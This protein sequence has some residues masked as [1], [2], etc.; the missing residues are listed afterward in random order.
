M[1]N[2]EEIEK[3]KDFMMREH[4]TLAISESVTSGHLQAALSLADGATNFFQ[5]GLT[6]YNLGQKSRH[7]KVDPILALSCNC[8]SEKVSEQMAL[9]TLEMFSCNWAIAITGYAAPVPEKGIHDL[10]AHYAIAFERKIFQ[11]KKITT[12]AKDPLEGALRARVT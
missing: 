1:Y 5:G 8:V 2:R 7:L 4:E 9:H 12:T 6:A 3:I 10:Y 11:A